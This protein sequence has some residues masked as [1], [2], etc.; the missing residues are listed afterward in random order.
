MIMKQQMTVK[1]KP[2]SEMFMTKMLDQM[3][4]LV[5]EKLANLKTFIPIIFTIVTSVIAFFFVTEFKISEESSVQF[6][7]LVLGVLLCAFI[8]LIVSSFTL[9]DYSGTKKEK[10]QQILVP[11]KLSTY[12]ELSDAQFVLCIKNYVKRPL[13]EEEC[14]RAN[15]LKQKINELKFRKQWVTFALWIVVIGTLNIAITCF[16]LAFK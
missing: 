2:K 15:M 10:P 16:I 3:E 13:T 8:A 7:M 9:I 4:K 5:D 1:Q 14:L 11:Y 6:Y 12:L